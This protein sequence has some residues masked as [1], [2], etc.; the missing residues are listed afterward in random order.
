MGFDGIQPP[1]L[2]EGWPAAR[3]SLVLAPSSPESRELL[4]AVGLA[5]EGADWKQWQARHVLGWPAPSSLDGPTTRRQGGRPTGLRR[6]LKMSN[7]CV[8]LQWPGHGGEAGGGEARP[9]DGGGAACCWLTWRRRGGGDDLHPSL[10]L[11]GA[12]SDWQEKKKKIGREYQANDKQA[13]EQDRIQTCIHPCGWRFVQLAI[14]EQSGDGGGE[15]RGR[16][17]VWRRG[18]VPRR[19]VPC[20]V[21]P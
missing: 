14:G 1:R 16:G 6:L 20:L 2:G 4:G 17:R 21:G 13:S 3:T 9:E 15:I 5:R 12:A 10:P 19:A 18:S 11:S 8:L 7:G